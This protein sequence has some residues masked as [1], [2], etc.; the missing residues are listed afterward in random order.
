MR[1]FR[2]DVLGQEHTHNLGGGDH[3]GWVSNECPTTHQRVAC[4]SG[5]L[6]LRPLST[7]YTVLLRAYAKVVY[8]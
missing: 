7:A 6:V 2:S 5:F 3:G 1:I 4:A 8:T